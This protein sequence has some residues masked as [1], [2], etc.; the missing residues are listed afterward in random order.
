MDRFEKRNSHAM[1]VDVVSRSHRESAAIK[2]KAGKRE[3]TDWPSMH[4]CTG[5]EETEGSRVGNK[6]HGPTLAHG[7]RGT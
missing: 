3:R 4:A 2:A 1:D 6:S 7:Q 5:N